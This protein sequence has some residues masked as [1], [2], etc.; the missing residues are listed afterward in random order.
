MDRLAVRVVL[1]AA[2]RVLEAVMDRISV[3]TDRVELRGF[4]KEHPEVRLYYPDGERQ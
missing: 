1:L 3:A 4:L 2:L